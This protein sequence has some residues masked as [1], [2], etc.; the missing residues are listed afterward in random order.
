MFFLY[1]HKKRKQSI[2]KPQNRNQK[3]AQ[4]NK[5]ATVKKQLWK[6]V[7]AFATLPLDGG[8]GDGISVK[9]FLW[10]TC[11]AAGLSNFSQCL[12]SKTNFTKHTFSLKIERFNFVRIHI[13]IFPAFMFTRAIS[14]LEFLI[15]LKHFRVIIKMKARLCW[16]SSCLPTCILSNFLQNVPSL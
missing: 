6:L 16:N 10:K 3:L 4:E 2:G 7:F 8:F 1:V 13:Q 9:H 14:S 11:F 15:V 12:W 5:S